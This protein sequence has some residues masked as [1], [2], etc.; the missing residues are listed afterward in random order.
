MHA[1]R[2]G[3]SGA[4]LG[5][6]REDEIGTKPD[7]VVGMSPDAVWRPR[8]GAGLL[9]VWNSLLIYNPQLALHAL[10]E[11]KV[12]PAQTQ[13]LLTKWL[14]LAPEAKGMLSRKLYA[15]GLSAV[16]SVEPC[17][18]QSTTSEAPNT[19]GVSRRPRQHEEEQ[20]GQDLW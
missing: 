4:S 7:G 11:G 13:L 5:P 20:G 9:D 19:R 12:T 2:G 18:A 3:G 16:L 6:P 1:P 15:L 14:E 10:D 17:P 8:L